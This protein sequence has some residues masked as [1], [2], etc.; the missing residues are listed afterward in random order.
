VTNDEEDFLIKALPSN[1]FFSRFNFTTSIGVIVD[2]LIIRFNQLIHTVTR[3]MTILISYL[4][5][6]PN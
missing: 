1:I 3:G 5:V 2:A 4:N 6:K